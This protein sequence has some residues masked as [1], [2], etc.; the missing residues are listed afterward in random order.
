MTTPATTTPLHLDLGTFEGPIDV[1][2]H[3][4]RQQ[5]VDLSKIS[6]LALVE[7]YISYVQAMRQLDL[8]IAAD[9]LVMAAWLAYLKSRLLLPSPPPADEPDAVMLSSSLQLQLQRLATMQ[10]LAERLMAQPRLYIDVQPRGVTAGGVSITFKPLYYSDVPSLIGAY[11]RLHREKNAH[12]PLVIDPVQLV[13][14]EEALQHLMHL[15]PQA[16]SWVNLQQFML[17][18]DTS[19]LQRRSALAATLVASLELARQGKIE[20]QQTDP[21]GPVYIRQRTEAAVSDDTSNP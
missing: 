4:A 1:L 12:A 17:S 19:V 6:I 8:D 11:A 13:S 2:L 9:Y 10:H 5:K 16:V 14:V 21:F 15:L 18:D 20:L 7:Q 3:L